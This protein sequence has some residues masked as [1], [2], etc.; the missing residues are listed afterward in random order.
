M[1]LLN[2]PWVITII[3]GFVVY[4]LTRSLSRKKSD[5]ESSA[6]AGDALIAILLF[7]LLQVGLPIFKDS[8]FKSIV[9]DYGME[10]YIFL[11]EILTIIIVVLAIEKRKQN[12]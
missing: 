12:R 8:I 10:L 4:F 6:R 9:E 5:S 11:Y 2:N 3:G 1:S 7:L